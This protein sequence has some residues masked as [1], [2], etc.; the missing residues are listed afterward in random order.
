MASYDTARE[1]LIR[2]FPNE[3]FRPQPSGDWQGE[4]PLPDPVAE[5]FA[6]LGPVD[7]WIPGYGNPYFLPS[8]AGLWGFQ[9]GYRYHPDTHRPFSD[10]DDDWLVV[11]DEGG[12]PFI[13][14]RA[15]FAVL[16]AYH[17]SGVWEPAVLFNDLAEMVTSVA[18]IGDI[19][20]SAGQLL[21]DD[22]SIIL[23][24]HQ[25]DARKRI[26]D[27]LHSMER[28]DILLQRLGWT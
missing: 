28:A 24:H 5:Y 27:Y 13:F 4:F 18:I 23:P 22:D 19:V 14:S 26:G 10:W 8:L 6:E 7:A 17:G 11:A 9:A 1:I 25:D 20:Q 3:V 21:T 16:H 15:S 12:D 2:A